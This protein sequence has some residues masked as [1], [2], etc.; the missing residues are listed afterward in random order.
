MSSRLEYRH[1]EI[2]CDTCDSKN[3]KTPVMCA[4]A[5]A[6]ERLIIGLFTNHFRVINFTFF[7]GSFPFR[8]SNKKQRV[9]VIK[10][11]RCFL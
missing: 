1:L 7:G 8:I 2:S 11:T 6:R 9:V 3:T 10:T 5:Y 4:Y